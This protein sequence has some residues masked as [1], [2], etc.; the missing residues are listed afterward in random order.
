MAETQTAQ[1][2]ETTEA[3]PTLDD[4]YRDFNI[5]VTAPA[6]TTE[7]KSPV[8]E[9]VAPPAP[10]LPDFYDPE[11]IKAWAASHAGQTSALQAQVQQL[12][13]VI[14]STQMESRKAAVDKDISQ[15][16]E[17]VNQSVKLPDAQK[18]LIEYALEDKARTDPRF[19]QIWD[20]RG[21]N[22]IA[23]NRALSAVSREIADTFSVRVDPQLAANRRALR[24]S[25]A[26]SATTQNAETE[27]PAWQSLP[28]DS[29][30][31]QQN[32]NKMVRGY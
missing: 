9:T 5:T 15:A 19:K 21:Q 17:T 14:S 12:T 18:K 24:E 25:Q 30:E 16:V 6:A 31:F 4:V 13:G 1:A 22:P 26:A 11:K 20:G 10:D 8:K 32:W 2:Q 23:W 27:T 29:V 3:V 28:A 7:T